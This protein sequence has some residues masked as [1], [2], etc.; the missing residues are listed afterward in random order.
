M[1]ETLSQNNK[2]LQQLAALVDEKVD[3]CIFAIRRE[4][5]NFENSWLPT[6]EFVLEAPSHFV[7]FIG[8]NTVIT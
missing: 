3:E 7:K 4:Y 2:T 5:T 8:Y 6:E 1:L